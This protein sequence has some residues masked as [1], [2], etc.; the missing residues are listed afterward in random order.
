M[1]ALTILIELVLLILSNKKFSHNYKSDKKIKIFNSALQCNTLKY[2]LSVNLTE[3]SYKPDALA[4][5]CWLE[6]RDL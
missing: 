1:Y 2:E 6:V 3:A 4:T 5:G